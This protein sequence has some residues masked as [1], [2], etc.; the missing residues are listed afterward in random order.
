MEKFNTSLISKENGKKMF[1]TA[2]RIKI[3][4]KPVLKLN[5]HEYGE[6]DIP[7]LESLGIDKQD[8]NSEN[9]RYLL[10]HNQ[11]DFLTIR[12]TILEKYNEEEIGHRVFLE[13]K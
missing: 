4:G 9:M 1:M 11:E 12:A 13:T 7:F 10:I 8:S 3:E 2:N 6:E 5:I